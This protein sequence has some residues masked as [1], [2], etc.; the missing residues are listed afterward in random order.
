MNQ[1]LY[2]TALLRRDELLQQ[3]SE[4]RRVARAV[5]QSP[6]ARFVNRLAVRALDGRL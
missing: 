4:W 6:R 1:L 3:A 2:Q 5:P